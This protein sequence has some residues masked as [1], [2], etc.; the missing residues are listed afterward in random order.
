MHSQ[1][2]GLPVLLLHMLLLDMHAVT[3]TVLLLH[4]L[5]STIH[6]LNERSAVI[7][8]CALQS[9][10][11]LLAACTGSANHYLLIADL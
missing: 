2:A 6:A 7:T 3:C 11:S 10:L 9:F 5:L 4:V 8:L 1:L